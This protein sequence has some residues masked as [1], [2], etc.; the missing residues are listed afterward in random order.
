MHNG[1]F[2]LVR[3][4]FC[5]QHR[6]PDDIFWPVVCTD[7]LGAYAGETGE[8]LRPVRSRQRTTWIFGMVMGRLWS[9]T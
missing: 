4:H 9:T 1:W 7:A 5:D 3:N 2:T 6:S 8:A